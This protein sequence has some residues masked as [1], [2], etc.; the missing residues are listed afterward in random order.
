MQIVNTR[1]L[2]VSAATLPKPTWNERVS[3]SRVLFA[4]QRR[5]SRRRSEREK[6]RPTHR[7][8]ARHCEVQCGDIHRLLG[9][10]VD[11]L[12]RICIVHPHVRVRAL[13]DVRQLPKPAVLNLKRE[14]ERAESKQISFSKITFCR[15]ANSSKGTENGAVIE[16]EWR[17]DL[18]VSPIHSSSE[19]FPLVLYH[20]NSIIT[21]PV[22]SVAPSD[23]IP[24][25]CQ[26]M[27]DQHVKAQ[28]KDQHRGTIL[29]I[30]I[31]LS[32]DPTQT[33]QTHHF[34]CTKQ[35]SNSLY[36]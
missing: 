7:S 8:H 1:S 5:T 32:H 13:R 22:L 12:G 4:H 21:H 36:Q 17:P 26:P 24:D 35:R 11:Y 16:F 6:E 34:Q 9:G 23:R 15:Q 29:Q 18:L 28:Q 25:A 14:D 33:K 27:S 20:E 2:S 3:S 19:R 30:S 31:Q 10:T